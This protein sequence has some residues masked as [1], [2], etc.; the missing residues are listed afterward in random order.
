[1]PPPPRARSKAKRMA[2]GDRDH[3]C[4]LLP[5]RL[6]PNQSAPPLCPKILMAFASRYGWTKAASGLVRAGPKDQRDDRRDLHSG[7]AERKNGAGPVIK[8]VYDR[9]WARLS[10]L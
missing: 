7:S 10:G 6:D 8:M 5:G 3:E 9:G 2:A 4:R 1:M